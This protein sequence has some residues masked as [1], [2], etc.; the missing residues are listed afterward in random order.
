SSDA[1]GRSAQRALLAV[2]LDRPGPLEVVEQDRLDVECQHD[3]VADEHATVRELVLRG[4][5]PVVA[6]DPCA[7][8][9]PDPPQLAPVLLADPEGRLPLTEVV[10]VERD[11]AR[12]A[13]NR[14][15]GLT[16]ERRA[17]GLFRETPREGD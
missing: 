16:L 14:Q 15:L 3:L 6:V 9:E 5:A 1:A 10:D 7:R 17:A 8:R 13:P 12:H 11:G 4:D 2:V